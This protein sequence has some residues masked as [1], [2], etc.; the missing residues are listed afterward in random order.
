MTKKE[1]NK[2]D[3]ICGSDIYRI[4]K[5]NLKDKGYDVNVDCIKAIFEVYA[6]LAYTCMINGKRIMIPNIGELYRDIQKGRKAGYYNV[7]NSRDDHTAF[8][9]N[10]EWHKEY[11]PQAPNWGKIPLSVFPRVK[12]KF[13]EETTGK[14]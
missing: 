3:L 11:M 8:D 5:K 12:K 9:K 10:M 14:C 4:I 6:D 1:R 7:P 2:M 13:R